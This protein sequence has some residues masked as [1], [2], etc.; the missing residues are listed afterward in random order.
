M[1]LFQIR[2]L[3]RSHKILIQLLGDSLIVLTCF[4]AAMI[5]RLESVSFTWTWQVWATLAVVVPLTLASFSVLGLYRAVVRYFSADS[6]P[7]VLIGA[8]VS[9]VAL[10]TSS[11]LLGA[12]IPRSVALI[13]F[14]LVFVGVSAARFYMRGLLARERRRRRRGAVIYGAGESGRQ[15]ANALH[16]DGDTAPVAFIDDDPKLQ[17]QVVA[18]KPV[19]GRDRLPEIVGN[20]E[21]SRLLLAVPGASREQRRSIVNEVADLEVEVRTIPAMEDIIDGRAGFGDLRHVDPEDL[22]GRDPIPPHRDLMG[23]AVQGKRVLVSGAGGSI[24]SELCRQ[25]LRERP[26]I[27]VL[28]EVSEFALFSVTHELREMIRRDGLEIRLIPILGCIRDAGRLQAALREFAVHTVYHAAAYKHVALVEENVMEGLRNNALGTAVAARAAIATG[29][30]R[31]ILVSTDKAVR[32]TNV[33]GA[34]KRLAELVCQAQATA[35]ERTVFSMVR[36]GNVLGSSGSVIPRFRKQIE[37][38]GPLTVTHAQI[39]RYFMTIPEASQLVIQA[40]AMARGG[41]VF[42]LD[43]GEAVR[44]LDLARSMIHLH[45]L[46]P[47]MGDDKGDIRIEIVGLDKGEKLYEELLIGDNP[48]P[49]DHPR[50]MTAEEQFLSLDELQPF[51]DRLENASMRNDVGTAREILEQLPLGY[52]PDTQTHDILWREA[53]PR[54][55]LE[56]AVA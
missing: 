3:E 56:T 13:Y 14:G 50:I 45:G 16:H 11:Q 15:L 32:P 35:Q 30:E 51:L 34:S 41:D 46:K 31:F 2:N 36:F 40:G 4:V 10:L 37:E 33:M 19:L 43:M 42:V 22:L 25:I 53:S 28:Y 9:S 39:T 38:G 52:K 6:L 55:D 27:L 54:G 12:P 20:H 29:V 1:D 18:G 24:G 44:I 8:L 23:A 17:G 21:I 26:E 47:C 5:V 49:T 7:V 48:Q